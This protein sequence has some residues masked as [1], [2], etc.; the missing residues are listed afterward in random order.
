MKTF[1]CLMS[2]L[3]LA[4]SVAQAGTE[5]VNPGVAT[6]ATTALNF[7]V[8]QLDAAAVQTLIIVPPSS[9]GGDFTFRLRQR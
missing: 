4:C 5:S 3:V 7:S 6:V 1:T 8:S 2:Y 9:P